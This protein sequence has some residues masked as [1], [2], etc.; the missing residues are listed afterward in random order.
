MKSSTTTGDICINING[1]IFHLCKLDYTIFEDDSFEYTFYPNYSVIDLLTEKE[2]NGIPGLNL[3]L[4]LDK[5]VRKDAIPTFISERVPL[6]NREDFDEIFQKLNLSYWNPI[7]YLLKT[8][9]QYH[10]DNLFMLPHEENQTINIDEIKGKSNICGIIDLLLKDIT[11]G[12]TII[13][14]STVI[15]DLNRKDFYNV[16][17]DLYLKNRK[18]TLAKRLEGID[19]AKAQHKYKGRKPI[20]VDPLMF[21]ECLDLI[22]EKKITAKE[23]AKRLKISIDKFYRYKKSL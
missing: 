18:H 16:F 14:N 9:L 1:I 20:N 22:Q 8:R 4:K 10:G 11:N 13:Y 19:N 21:E 17:L 12:N 15:N 7:D 5:Y 6:K 23:A 3:D 2:F